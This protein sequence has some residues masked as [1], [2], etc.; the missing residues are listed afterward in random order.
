LVPLVNFPR[1]LFLEKLPSLEKAL[2]FLA[3]TSFGGSNTIKKFPF[4]GS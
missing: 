3:L 4:L 1:E 2:N